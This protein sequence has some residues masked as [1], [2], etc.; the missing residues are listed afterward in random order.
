MMMLMDDDGGDDDDDEDDDLMMVMME[1]VVVVRSKM[2]RLARRWC[3]SCGSWMSIPLIMMDLLVVG[4]G[5]DLVNCFS[6]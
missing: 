2:M 6:L 5:V 1:S 4:R 3:L